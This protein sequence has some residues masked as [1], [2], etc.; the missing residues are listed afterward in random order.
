MGLIVKKNTKIKEID[1]RDKDGLRHC[2]SGPACIYIT[3]WNEIVELFYIR[4]VFYTNYKD[5]EEDALRC[6]LEILMGL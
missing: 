5:W 1:I 2:L 3:D 4:G 6:R